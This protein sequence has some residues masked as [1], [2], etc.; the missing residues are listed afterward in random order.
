MRTKKS[1][2]LSS[3]EY[4][5]IISEINTNYSKYE[6]KRFA[7]HSSYGIDNKAYIYFFENIGYNNYNIYLRMEI[8]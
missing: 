7:A 1:F 6:G 3:G 4:A 8:V 5:K 2:Y